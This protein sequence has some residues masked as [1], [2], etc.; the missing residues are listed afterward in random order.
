MVASSFALAGVAFAMI[1]TMGWLRGRVENFEVDTRYLKLTAE[2]LERSDG[3]MVT[4][5]S[6][7]EVTS[8]SVDE[9]RLQ[10]C[11]GVESGEELRLDDQYQG[12][13]PHEL[14]EI[15]HL[16]HQQAKLCTPPEDG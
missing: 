1:W 16:F 2:G 11:I 8:V 9:D 7:A 12:A 15:I 4:V 6:W 5:L 13:A 14:A 3:R 10:V